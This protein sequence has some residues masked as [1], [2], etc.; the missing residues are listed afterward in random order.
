MVNQIIDYAL[1]NFNFGYVISINILAYII[2]SLISHI[3][4]QQIKKIIKILI[5]CAISIIMF[6]IYKLCSNI[7]TDILINSTIL[8]PVAWDWII[9]PI[10]EKL[11]IDYNN[12]ASTTENG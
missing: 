4:K 9:K 5:T 3:S 2:I 12:Y 7:E 10:F 8:A 1:N 11:K 6:I